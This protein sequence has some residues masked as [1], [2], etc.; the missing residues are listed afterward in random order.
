MGEDTLKCP[1]CGREQHCH[2]PDDIDALMANTECEHCGK[3]FEYS[4]SVVR[5]YDSR[6]ID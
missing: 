6:K 4:V 3:L 1:Y 2:E 5:T